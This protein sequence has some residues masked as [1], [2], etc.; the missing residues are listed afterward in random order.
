M[1]NNPQRI[2]DHDVEAEASVLGSIIL[3][4]DVLDEVA[5]EIESTDYWDERH[6]TI[7]EHLL[8]MRS[9]GDAIDIQLLCDRLKRAGQFDE[10]GGA[11]AL[12]RL[13]QAVPNA[14]HAK[15]YAG[16][17]R[18]RSL[19]RDLLR[20]AE[21]LTEIA[22]TAE[23]AREALPDAEA[24][25]FAVGQRHAKADHLYDAMTITREAMDRLEARKAGT[26][27]NGTPTGFADLDRDIGGLKAG[28]L[29]VL[30]A[31]PSMGK[32]ALAMNI[33]EHLAID[34]QV[35]V[36]MISLEMSHSELSDRLLASR[37]RVPLPAIMKADLTRDQNER[38]QEAAADSSQC[39]LLIDVAPTRTTAEIAAIARRA[40]RKRQLGAIVIDYLQL[41]S[42][43]TARETKEE[44][45]SRCS[46]QLKA[47]ARE[48]QVP[49]L[50]LAQ[51][52][53]ANE[54][55]ETKRPRLSNLRDSGAIE[56]DADIV[57]FVHRQSY[58]DRQ[59]GHAPNDDSDAEIIIA[60]QRNGPTGSVHLTWCGDIVRFDNR[61]FKDEFPGH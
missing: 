22:G 9:A 47:L 32:T 1:S 45:V 50:C 40:N 18:E 23:D 27:D 58:Y 4:P 48:L 60:K 13:A 12:A 59:Q 14:A 24:A 44:H 57:M 37:S 28:E 29:L 8:A 25:M 7:H 20:T 53:R 21:K 26:V 33:V 34:R 5:T 41:I 15:H 39:P 46:R 10:V 30:A 31:R 36:L 56:Q 6:R 61:Y 51:L 52:N 17:I 19:R 2:Q 3:K 11:A 54:H 38:V 43:Q 49:L 42:G 16:V 55:T 35:P